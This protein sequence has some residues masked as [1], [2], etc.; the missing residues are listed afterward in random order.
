MRT[1]HKGKIA[2]NLLCAVVGAASRFMDLS[3]AQ[4]GDNGFSPSALLDEAEQNILR[5][6]KHTTIPKLQILLIL[7]YDRTMSGG[8]STVWYLTAL[9]S[10]TA[11]G[12]KPNH[13]VERIPFTNQECRRRLMWCTY[14]S[15]NFINGG[16]LFCS[17]PAGIHANST[18]L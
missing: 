8:L 12:L 6:M 2:R 13:P 17:L 10:R 9:A 15:G 1:W 3:S 5:D 4:Q 14:I 16:I 7:L 18:T 11:F